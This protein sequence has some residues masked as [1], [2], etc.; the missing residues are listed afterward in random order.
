M[1]SWPPRALTALALIL[2]A[3]SAAALTP[4]EAWAGWQALGST[5]GQT[6]TATGTA[7]A[8]D[9]L[10][11][12]GITVAAGQADT[13]AV[14]V[15]IAS[16]D[17]KDRGDGTVEITYPPSY[18]ATLTFGPE[19][20][21]G[22][23]SFVLAIAQ[24]QLAVIASGSAEAPKY[25]YTAATITATAKD[26]VRQDGAAADVNGV[27]T[28]TGLSG[29][30]A[31]APAGSAKALDSNFAAKTLG[32]TVTGSIPDASKTFSANLS[33][34][35]IAFKGATVMVDP[36]LLEAGNMSAALAAGFRVDGGGTTGPV[37]LVVDAKDHDT[38]NHLD[39]TLTGTEVH[40]LMDAARLDYGFGL[41]GGTVKATGF[42]MP[43]PEVASA[44]GEIGLGFAMPVKASDEPQPF[45]ALVK[46]V[47][48]TLTE[49]VW[50]IFDP[51][52]RLPRDPVSLIVDL[53]G[54]G[55][56]TVDI[57]DPAAQMENGP[58]LPAKLFTLDLTQVLAQAVGTKVVAIG[59]LTFDNANLEQ[60]GGFPAPNGKI[61]VTMDGINALMD[62]LVAIGMV[63]Q[64]DLMSARMGLAMMA[65][66]GVGP[67]QLISEIDF[68]DGGLFVNGQQMF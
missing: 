4:E 10:T 54:T 15:A 64:D 37:K 65:K 66:P 2:S 21:D 5:S 19:M 49:E 25:D 57:M 14:A 11:V 62:A 35:D 32:L 51:G 26:F 63:S 28:L 16:V 13:M 46:L 67:D 40:A 42:D 52:A 30:Y 68:R 6:I 60:Y 12:S 7:R 18:D 9:T 43:F 45:S 34:S 59:G 20:R 29:S 1:Y 3:Q 24:D 44:F 48:L 41:N 23:K 47:D 50:A 17:F 55:A 33:T 56:W 58:D 61:T 36:A 27:L 53:A 22:P 8:G 38:P 39:L 31:A